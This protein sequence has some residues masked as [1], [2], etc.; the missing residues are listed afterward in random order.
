MINITITKLFSALQSVFLQ[1]KYKIF[2]VIKTRIN[3]LNLKSYFNALISVKSICA[4]WT[5]FHF[6]WIIACWIV[7]HSCKMVAGDS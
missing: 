6:F 3:I 2:L 7:L 1:T 5:K 4:H